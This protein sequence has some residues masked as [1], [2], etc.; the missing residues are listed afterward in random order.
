MSFKHVENDDKA[1]QKRVDYLWR[2]VRVY[3]H[4]IRMQ[5]RTTTLV[6][7]KSMKEAQGEITSS[8]SYGNEN[9]D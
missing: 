4:T 5:A 9:I 1:M 8:W 2:T 7:R 3:V 6:K